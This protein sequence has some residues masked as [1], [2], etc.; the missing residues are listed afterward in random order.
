MRAWIGI[1]TLW[2][3]F[4]APAFGENRLALVIGNDRDKNI[5]VLQKAKAD[6]QGYAALLRE[7]GFRSR[8]VMI[9]G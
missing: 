1:C 8:K 5:D 6:A 3:C 9:P 7:K 4:A 2:L